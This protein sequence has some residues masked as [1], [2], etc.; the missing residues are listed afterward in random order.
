M[1]EK[2]EISNRLKVFS[3]YVIFSYFILILS[4]KVLGPSKLVYPDDFP[5]SCPDDSIKFTTSLR[6]NP[7]SITIV[8]QFLRG[9]EILLVMYGK[10][11]LI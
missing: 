5:E 11:K 2:M 10:L 8:R 7:L 4:I 6:L 1:K 3:F 9:L